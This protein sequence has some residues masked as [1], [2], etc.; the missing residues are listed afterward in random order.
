MADDNK[1]VI[2]IESILG[3]HSP[4]E[5]FAA[6]DQYKFSYGIDPSLPRAVGQPRG[7]SSGLIRPTFVQSITNTAFAAA[8]M[9][10]TQNPKNSL[11]YVYD[12]VGSVY[13]NSNNSTISGLG[14]LNDGG[15]STG[16]G[17]AYYDN[18]IYFA[19]DTTVARYGP[20]DGTAAFTDDYWAGTLG[21]TALTDP[22]FPTVVSFSPV[23]YPNHV[24]HRHSDGRL[25]IADVVDNKG[26]I[27][28]IQTTK[29]TVEGDTDNGSTYNKLQF[30]YGLWPTAIESYGDGLVIALAEMES[31]AF[32][33]AQK[34]KLAFWD[35][36]SQN[37]NQIIWEEFPD[38]MITGLK[39]LNGVLYIV[40]GSPFITGF[41]LTRYIGG[42]SFEEVYYSEDGIA[43]LQ[44]AIIATGQRLLFG[45]KHSIGNANGGCVYSWGLQKSSLGR[46]IFIPYGTTGGEFVSSLSFPDSRSIN[47]GFGFNTPTIGWAGNGPTYGLDMVL[48]AGA[49]QYPGTIYYSSEWQSQIYKIGQ[50]FKIKKI[51]IPTPIGI[52]TII[53]P[54]V[55]T[56]F[57]SNSYPLTAITSGGDFGGTQKGSLGLLQILQGENITGDGD[58]HLVLIWSDG[59]GGGGT[60]GTIGLPITIEYELL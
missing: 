38:Q 9:W 1:R 23:S 51:Y 37:F 31:G 15:T 35:T 18:Y 54:T 45:S 39:N 36:T 19:R 6:E 55:Y 3:G 21:K 30:G 26:T 5:Y 59:S 8:P 22:S 33:G 10:Q 24:M 56:D 53:T 2:K 28:F 42:N 14:D 50:P 46:G 27:H 7:R 57:R 48:I 16:N 17:A 32:I 11:V 43:P 13:T 44:G 52:N 58:F 41:R 29:T 40:S 25:Y 20:L 60:D 4:S 12:M 34:A 49:S 47:L